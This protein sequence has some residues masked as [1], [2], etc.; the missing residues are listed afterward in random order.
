[1]RTHNIPFSISK[2]KN[3]LNHSKSVAMGWMDG[4]MFELFID[5]Q[6]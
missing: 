1:M 2:T 6:P 3:T 4:R 5:A